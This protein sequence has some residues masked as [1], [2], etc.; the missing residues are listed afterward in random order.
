VGAVGAWVLYTFPPTA[1]AFYPQCPFRMMTGL[2]CPGCGTTRALHHLL[3]G[4]IEEAFR[5]NPMLFV[6][7]AVALCALPS[8]V[9]GRHPAFLMKPWFAWTAF[10]VLATY[11]ILRNTPLYPF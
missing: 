6:L 10:V 2:E 3:H 5:L 4:R 1:Y 9:R 8:V 7:L 11:W